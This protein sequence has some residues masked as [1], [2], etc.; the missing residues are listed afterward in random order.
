[1]KVRPYV[2][3]KKGLKEKPGSYGLILRGEGII[4]SIVSN[5]CVAGVTSEEY[6]NLP[7]DRVTPDIPGQVVWK[8]RHRHCL[9]GSLDTS[10]FVFLHHR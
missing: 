3:A 2:I 8:G 4:S 1:M 9:A 5:V 10:P 6:D 7:L